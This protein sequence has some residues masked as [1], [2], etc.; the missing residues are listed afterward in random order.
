MPQID[1][2]E[3]QNHGTFYKRGGV[4]KREGGRRRERDDERH[5]FLYYF[6]SFANMHIISHTSMFEKVFSP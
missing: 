1:E 4:K 6:P 3:W 2:R 5:L